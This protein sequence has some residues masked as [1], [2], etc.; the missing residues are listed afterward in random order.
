MIFFTLNRLFIRTQTVKPS[1]LFNSL[2]LLICFH[3]SIC[4]TSNKQVT[5]SQYI[6]GDHFFPRLL[7][8]HEGREIKAGSW[9]SMILLQKTELVKYKATKFSFFLALKSAEFDNIYKTTA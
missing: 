7:Y 4:A 3:I 6:V 2:C 9:L 8:L 1:V 5:A